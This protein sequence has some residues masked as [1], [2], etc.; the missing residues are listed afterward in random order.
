MTLCV[1]EPV[2][3]VFYLLFQVPWQST[4]GNEK[5]YFDNESVSSILN[6]IMFVGT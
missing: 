2:F 1:V 6:T 3:Y 4:G 5:Y